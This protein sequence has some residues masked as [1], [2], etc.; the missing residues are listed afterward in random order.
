MTPAITSLI[1]LCLYCHVL[2]SIATRPNFIFI[3]TDDQDIKLE[4]MQALPNVKKYIIDQGITFN[5][6]FIS[7]PICCPSRTE[8]ITG[9]NFQNTKTADVNLNNCMH[10]AAK[11]NVFNNSNSMFQIFHNNGYLTASFGKLTNDMTG[12]WCNNNPSLIGFDR[13]QCPCQFNNFYGLQYFDKFING[14]TKLITH[15]LTENIY[16]T[17]MIGNASIQWIKQQFT[18]QSSNPDTAKPF[19]IWIGP[20]APHY[21]ATPAAWY[22]EKFSNAKAPRTVNYNVSTVNHHAFVSKNPYISYNASLWVDQ[23]YR[24]RL[25]SLLSVDDLVRDLF[26][27]MSGYPEQ[28]D[29]TYILYNSDHGYEYFMTTYK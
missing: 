18:A 23:L 21:P 7:T 5:N 28:L 16:Q 13:I 29:N 12:F 27:M 15:N 4:S 9:R 14:T 17:P 3:L 19:I 1:L 26:E 20:H 22:T 10:S 24:D 6:S 11:Y 2:T 8:T 25:R